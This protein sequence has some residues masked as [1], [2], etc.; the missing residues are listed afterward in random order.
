[1]VDALRALLHP[2]YST[3]TR[4]VK[5]QSG[6]GQRSTKPSGQTLDHTWL[7]SHHHLVGAVV[8]RRAIQAHLRISAVGP[9]D[10][11]STPT[12]LLRQQPCKR[13]R[14][15]HQ[16]PHHA[17]QRKHNTHNSRLHVLLI[18]LERVCVH[19]AHHRRPAAHFRVHNVVRRPG[20]WQQLLCER[21]V[22]GAVDGVGE[23]GACQGEAEQAAG[24]LANVHVTARHVHQVARLCW[25]DAHCSL[26]ELGQR[27][28][29][30]VER[31]ST[32]HGGLAGNHATT[33]PQQADGKHDH[34][35]HQQH[36][37]QRVGYTSSDEQA[38]RCAGWSAAADHAAAAL[39]QRPPNVYGPC[40]K[41]DDDNK[42]N[43]CSQEGWQHTCKGCWRRQADQLCND[44]GVQ[45]C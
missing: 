42:C 8:N 18:Q 44:L 31:V 2:T 33:Q 29:H 17:Q 4:L 34:H 40:C 7:Q 9:A 20:C 12:L 25:V 36:K 14:H 39:L 30:N 10:T 1:M 38:A 24:R 28:V 27:H 13:A 22:A 6:H 15:E 45:Q 43:R 26:D 32:I 41:G 23:H 19:T 5:H 16:Q 3:H 35:P 11:T 21:R 37:Q